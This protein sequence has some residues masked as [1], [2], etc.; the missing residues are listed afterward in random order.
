MEHVSMAFNRIHVAVW[1]DSRANIAKRKYN[2]AEVILIHVQTGPNA[3]TISHI[4]HA[5]AWLD[6]AESIVLRILMIVR[7]TCVKMAE[8]VLTASIHITVNVRVNLLE[9]SVKE[10]Q[11]YR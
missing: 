4:T 3:L 7:I 11:W 6:S 9:N 2:F 1:P 8:H 5:N 10:H